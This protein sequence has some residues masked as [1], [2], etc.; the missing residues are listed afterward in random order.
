[1]LAWT[2]LAAAAAALSPD[3]DTADALLYGA[4]VGAV[5]YN[6]FNGTIL[7]IAPEWRQHIGVSVVDVVWGSFSLAGSTWVAVTVAKT[8]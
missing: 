7:A 8:W 2:S 3:N 6:V 1:M 5:A 4:C